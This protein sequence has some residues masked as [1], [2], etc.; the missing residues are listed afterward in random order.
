MS[1]HKLP[2]ETREARGLVG[3]KSEKR[4]S[5]VVGMTVSPLKPG[6]RRWR[7]LEQACGMDPRLLTMFYDTHGR[8]LSKPSMVRSGDTP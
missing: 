2:S 6:S 7:D 4:K 1:E 8:W 3:I 5:P